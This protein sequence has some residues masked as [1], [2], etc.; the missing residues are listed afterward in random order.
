MGDD[1]DDGGVQLVLFAF[2][3][4]AA[5][6][7]GNVSAF[8]GDDEGAFKLAGV[9]GVDAEVGG[10]FHR[11]AHAGRDVAEAAVAEDGGVER[12]EVVVVHAYHA[13]QVLAHEF[14]VFAHR[15]GEGAEDDAFFAKAVFEAG[16]DRDGVK[17]GIDRNAGKHF[18]LL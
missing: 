10:E 18:P 1:F 7:V 15:F 9:G 6:E 17:D 3:R 5:F 12:G 14:R 2:W 13:A 4:G 8:V 16:G 11:A